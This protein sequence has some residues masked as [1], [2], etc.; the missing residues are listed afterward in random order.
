MARLTF[1]VVNHASSVSFVRQVAKSLPNPPRA[2]VVRRG[3]NLKLVDISE[4]LVAF[5]QEP[6]RPI[7]QLA[8]K[9]CIK[10]LSRKKLPEALLNKNMGPMDWPRWYLEKEKKVLLLTHIADGMAY[11]EAPFEATYLQLAAS[12]PDCVC[13]N[14]HEFFHGEGVPENRICSNCGARIICIH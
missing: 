7:G 9:D 5:S 4:V 14:R 13:L 2:I 1:P 11:F 12:A 8:L 6:F 10:T 3:F